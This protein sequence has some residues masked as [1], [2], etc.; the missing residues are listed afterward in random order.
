M[1]SKQASSIPSGTSQ[2]ST[3]A[4]QLSGE[5]GRWMMMQQAVIATGLT[6]RTLRR[7]IKK[8]LLKHRRTGRL[9]NS[10]LELWI[11]P[12]VSKFADQEDQDD[13]ENIEIFDVVPEGID[14]EMFDTAPEPPLVAH[15]AEHEDA[16]PKAADLERIVG[17]I[18]GQFLERLEKTNE[19]VFQLR[20]EL[21]D[22]D[23][24][25]KLLP[26]LQK[27]ANERELAELKSIALEKQIEELKQLNEQLKQEAEHAA[28]NARLAQ[29]K[30][31]WWKRFFTSGGPDS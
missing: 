15:S 14:E 25:L 3:E 8:G 11:N 2:S 6:E 31:S 24:Q 28:E 13:N 4:Q 22:K 17:A 1:Y 10:P 30:K 18:T 21:H 29:E 5:N 19:L 7:Y 27:Q 9:T 20:N 12:E 23:R 26:D 16:S